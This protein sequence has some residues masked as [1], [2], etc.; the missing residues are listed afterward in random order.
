MG[1]VVADSIKKIRMTI[2]NE[3][4]EIILTDTMP[5]LVIAGSVIEY[6]LHDVDEKIGIIEFE[7]EE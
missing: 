6:P 3:E 2:Y 4:G 5:Q 7:L 1:V